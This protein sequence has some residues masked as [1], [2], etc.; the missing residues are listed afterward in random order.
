ME[1]QLNEAVMVSV[2]LRTDQGRVPVVKPPPHP[3]GFW[4]QG[5]VEEAAF[6]L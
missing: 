1:I 2:G 4:A 5:Q 3:W 6:F